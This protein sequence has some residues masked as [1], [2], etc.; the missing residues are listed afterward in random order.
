MLGLRNSDSAISEAF[1]IDCA[2]TPALPAAD[3]GRISATLTWPVPTET[4]FTGAPPGGRSCDDGVVNWLRLC[5]TLEQAPS[6]GAPTI[7][8]S[9]VRR[10]ARKGKTDRPVP[11]SRLAGGCG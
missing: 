10:L 2:A 5:W 9:A 6:S 7:S 4:G 3:S 11:A 1:L 8:P